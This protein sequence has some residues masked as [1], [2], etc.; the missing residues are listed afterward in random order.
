MAAV[1]LPAVVAVFA[2]AVFGFFDLLPHRLVRRP[3]RHRV[4]LGFV[5]V[6]AIAFK[7][8]RGLHLFTGQ[9]FN[10]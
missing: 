3:H 9:C 7:T 4:G 1:V 8:E 10:A 6:A 2:L 5:L